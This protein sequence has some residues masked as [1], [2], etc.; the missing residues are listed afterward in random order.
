M[1][2]SWVR[3]WEGVSKLVREIFLDAQWLTSCPSISGYMR[4]I[5]AVA[6]RSRAILFVGASGV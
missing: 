6:L 5:M 2:L 3:R 4:S 1:D